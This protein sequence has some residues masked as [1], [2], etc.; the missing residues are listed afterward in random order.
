MKTGMSGVQHLNYIDC[1]AGP[2]KSE[3][4]NFSDTSPKIAITELLNARKALQ[5]RGKNVEMRFTFIEKDKA[6]YSNLEKVLSPFGAYDIESHNSEFT[7]TI[8]QIQAFID[9]KSANNFTFFFIDPTG[10]TGFAMDDIKGLLRSNRGEV[11]INLMT[12]DITRFVAEEFTENSFSKLFGQDRIEHIRSQA[13]TLSGRERED[14]VVE[15]YCNSLREFAGYDY[16]ASAVI[17]NPEQ[18]RNHFHLIYGTRNPIGLE[19]FG[20]ITDKL[21][22]Q[23]KVGR[24]LV[25]DKKENQEIDGSLQSCLF[26]SLERAEFNGDG[27]YIDELRGYYHSIGKAKIREKLVQAGSIL[28]DDLFAFA[29]QLPMISHKTLKAFL[30]EWKKGEDLDYCGFADGQRVPKIRENNKVLWLRN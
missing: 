13:K 23:Q 16:V 7:K 20:E 22:E 18:Q 19:K 12:K 24:A 26:S 3:T 5:E 2:W 6:A 30:A 17:A 29:L 15:E 4:E 8:P 10:W 28:Y 25:K 1:F 27:G 11:L 14:F 21:M 9:R